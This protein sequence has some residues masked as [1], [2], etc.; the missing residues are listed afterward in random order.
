MIAVAVPRRSD[1]RPQRWRSAWRSSIQ[2]L[3]AVALVQM[4]F[5][6]PSLGRDMT[7]GMLGPDWLSSARRRRCRRCGSSA[8]FEVLNGFSGRNAHPLAARRSA[9][10][11]RLDASAAVGSTR[12]GYQAPRDAGARDAA[13]RN[14]AGFRRAA[15]AVARR[16][17]TGQ[18]RAGAQSP[19]S[20][21]FTIRTLVR[22]RQHRTLV[23]LYAGLGVALVVSSILPLALQR[24]LAAFAR[25]GVAV[26]AAPLVMMFVSAGRD[27]R[28]VRDPGGDQGQLDRPAAR[29]GRH[30]TRRS[31]A[32]S[33]PCSPYGVVAVRRV[34]A[35]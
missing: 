1:P 22:S 7:D 3:F 35:P 6:L 21:Q 9:G 12:F 23:A 28:R 4:I 20:R 33:R 29:A 13:A 30:A 18:R 5:F 14:A 25:P 11:G 19:P 31:T 15:A 8:L 24:G 10:D 26:L 17:Q 34:S 2:M 27:A 16:G 32:S